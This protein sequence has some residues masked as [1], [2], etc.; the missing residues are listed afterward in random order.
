MVRPAGPGQAMLSPT[1]SPSRALPTGA[2]TE[3]FDSSPA[4]L[5]IDQRQ[6]KSLPLFCILKRTVLFMVTTSGGMSAG[7]RI[8]AIQLLLQGKVLGWLPSSC[9]MRS[10]PGWR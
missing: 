7:S 10:D 3:I 8:G 9:S 4:S 2:S 5:W 1:L 6:A